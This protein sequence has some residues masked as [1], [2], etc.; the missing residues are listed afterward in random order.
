[1]MDCRLIVKEKDADILIYG[2][3]FSNVVNHLAI[4]I[5]LFGDLKNII[6]LANFGD[7]DEFLKSYRYRQRPC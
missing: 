6:R 5:I 1:M 4:A 7:I 2:R 3:I